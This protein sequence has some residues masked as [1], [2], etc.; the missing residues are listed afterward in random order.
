MKN[1]KIEQFQKQE[2]YTY[3]KIRHVFLPKIWDYIKD[4]YIDYDSSFIKFVLEFFNY[5]IVEAQ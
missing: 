3:K 2:M 4:N 5:A 1:K